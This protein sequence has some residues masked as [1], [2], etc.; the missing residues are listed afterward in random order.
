M[1]TQ[2]V[3]PAVVLSEKVHSHDRTQRPAELVSSGPCNKLMPVGH[4]SLKDFCA[5]ARL[6]RTR[7]WLILLVALPMPPW[8]LPPLPLTLVQSD[9]RMQPSCLTAILKKHKL[10]LMESLTPQLALPFLP[11]AQ[12]LLL[13]LLLLRLRLRMRP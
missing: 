3:A 11:V 12:L 8:L 10:S 7:K 9:L 6:P 1:A 13:L 4:E 2:M 5:T